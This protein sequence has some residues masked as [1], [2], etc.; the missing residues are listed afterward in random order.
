ML[1]KAKFKAYHRI[2]S[3]WESWGPWCT[4][5]LVDRERERKSFLLPAQSAKCKMHLTNVVQKL[6]NV[7]VQDAKC[8]LLNIICIDNMWES[9]APDATTNRSRKSTLLPVPSFPQ[10]VVKL[11]LVKKCWLNIYCLEKCYLFKFS[12]YPFVNGSSWRVFTLTLLTPA[13][14][15]A[16]LFRR[17]ACTWN[18][19]SDG[20][21]CPSTR[22]GRRSPNY[23]Q[24]MPSGSKKISF[25]KCSNIQSSQIR[26]QPNCQLY[27]MIKHPLKSSSFPVTSVSFTL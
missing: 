16:Q 22:R 27:K 13:F 18:C 6:P 5:Q 9:R 25:T 11:K 23:T 21:S 7:F 14:M 4:N 17:P 26:F 20:K 8:I 10:S 3:M 12:S 15:Y 1:D 2:I 19:A 24:A